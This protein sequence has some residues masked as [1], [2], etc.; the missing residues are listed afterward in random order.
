[1]PL[2]NK[3][4]GDF[5]ISETPPVKDK[6]KHFNVFRTTWRYEIFLHGPAHIAAGFFIDTVRLQTYKARDLA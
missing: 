1:M 4:L 6:T 3:P 5:R 2:R